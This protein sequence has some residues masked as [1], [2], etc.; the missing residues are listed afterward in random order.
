MPALQ[1]E[2]RDRWERES[3]ERSSEADPAQ[4]WG[5]FLYEQSHSE[6]QETERHVQHPR[7]DHAQA[8]ARIVSAGSGERGSIDTKDT[9]DHGYRSEY[10]R[11]DLE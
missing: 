7:L 5:A 8:G 10:E 6:G 2:G 4:A 3:Q 11:R 1:E 9:P